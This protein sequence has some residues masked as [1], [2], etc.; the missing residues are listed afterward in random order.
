VNATRRPAAGGHEHGGGNVVDLRSDTVSQPTA[1]MRAAMA[2]AVVGDDVFGEDPTVRELEEV[3]AGLTGKEAA[4]FVPS[5]TMANLIAVLV[6]VPR[7]GEVI[8]DEES[9]L[10]LNEGGGASSLAGAM[11][12]T[13]RS[14]ADARFE[15][16]EL[17]RALR[18]PDN[19]HHPRSALVMLEDTHAHRMGQPLEPAYVEAVASWAHGHGLALH[20]DGARIANAAVALDREVR[21]LLAA[22]DSASLCLSKGLACPMGSLLVGGR[23][24][25]A[26][27]RR[28]R[29]ALGGGQRQVGIAAAAGVIALQRGEDGTIDRLA[30]DHRRAR[31]LAEGLAA[32]DGVV[33]DREPAT[34]IIIFRIQREGLGPDGSA[35][36]RDALVASAARE[37]VLLMRYPRGG[38]RAVTHLDIDDAGIERAL[39][40]VAAALP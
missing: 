22:A 31:R 32:V 37:G 2:R 23:R 26:E 38:I 35:A 34:N 36:L 8:A 15:L 1:A 29:K 12:R 27:A 5:G 10:V 25:I 17:D 33:L 20:V 18:D 3:V 16:Q 40:V 19:D 28:A 4:L 24:F 14:D 9:H 39:D 30:E 6:H 21:D 11:V 13:L 7:G